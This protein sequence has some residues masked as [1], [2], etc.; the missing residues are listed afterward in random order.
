MTAFR[1]ITWHHPRGYLALRAAAR[2]RAGSLDLT[3]DTQPLEAFEAHPIEEL[4]T[5]YDLI[6]LDHPHL[7]DALLYQCLRPLDELFSAQ[8]LAALAD[9]SVGATYA[10][11]VLGGR[12]WA[13][14]LDA[15]AQVLATRR[16]TREPPTTWEEVLAWSGK[17]ALSLAGPHAALTLFSMCVAFGAPPREEGP[18]LDLAAVEAAFDVLQRLHARAPSWTGSLNPIGLLDAMAQGADLDLVPLVY[19][20]VNYADPRPGIYRC[21]FT[22]RPR[23]S[24]GRPGSTLGG[25]GLAVSRRCQPSAAL[26]DHLRWLVSPWRSS[27]SCPSTRAAERARGVERAVAGGPSVLSRH[28]AHPG[29]RLGAP[30]E[31]RLC[32]VP[33]ARLAPGPR[34]AA[35]RGSPGHAGRG[36]EPALGRRAR[37]RASVHAEERGASSMG[38]VTLFKGDLI[39]EIVLDRPDKLNAMTPAM[40]EQLFEHVAA[41]N[42][43]D[44]VRAVVLT[45]SG[46]RAF[47]AGSDI[48]ELDGYA[49]PGRSATARTTATRCARAASRSSAR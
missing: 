11:Y 36:L 15:A 23:A 21:S 12:A 3:W 45:G 29:V 30:A 14:P 17:P 20:Y 34:G 42:R 5:R 31:R 44:E 39:A 28:L 40:A 41:C 9:R 19:G 8:E 24:G 38:R 18:L 49:T 47:C 27:A 16:D 26:I 10:S 32:A 48:K 35:A 1:G 25:T 43:D 6:V 4:A 46:E 7:G 22:R 33:G 2:E 13:L 37:R